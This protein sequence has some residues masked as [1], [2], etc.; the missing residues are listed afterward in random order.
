MAGLKY[1][2]GRSAISGA[3]LA[4]ADVPW[5]ISLRGIERLIGSNARRRPIKEGVHTLS[6]GQTSWVGI[7]HLHRSYNTTAIGGCAADPPIYPTTP[8][9]S[10]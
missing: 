4:L 7:A 5:Q 1:S 6:R 9:A 10:T 3:G 8:S 2:A